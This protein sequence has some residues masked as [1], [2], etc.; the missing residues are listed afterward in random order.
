MPEVIEICGW[1]AIP[2]NDGWYHIYAPGPSNALY[3]DKFRGAARTE[4]V[5]R[6]WLMDSSGETYRQL[7]PIKRSQVAVQRNDRIKTCEFPYHGWYQ[8]TVFLLN[9][10][11]LGRI[12]TKYIRKRTSV[13]VLSSK[14]EG[15]TVGGS[16]PLQWILERNGYRL[17]E[18]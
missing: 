4:E 8:H 5:A 15:C 12:Q 1:R 2:Q 7:P 18:G 13:L 14:D 11:E 10:T 3:G 6:K 17:I 9:G 16:D